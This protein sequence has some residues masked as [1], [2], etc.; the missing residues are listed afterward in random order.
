MI[1]NIKPAIRSQAEEIYAVAKSCLDGNEKL[2]EY[3]TEKI[4]DLMKTS[5][6]TSVVVCD[7]VVRGFCVCER[8]PIP[9]GCVIT[10]I[11]IEDGYRNSGLGRKLLSYSLREARGMRLKSVFLW[12]GESNKD[13]DRFFRKIGFLPDGKRRLTIP[14]SE[15]YEL[16]YR[17]DI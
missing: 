11:Y 3:Q 12:V 7:K 14:D 15:T 9:D 17:I 1:L 13:A 6:L 5:L 8:S 16:R 4:P 2:S 10:G